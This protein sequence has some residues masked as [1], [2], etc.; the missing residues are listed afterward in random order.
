MSRLND[1][2][3]SV[4]PVDRSLEAVV[5]RR[6]D[7]LTKPPGSLGR[8]EDLA[9][10][11]CLVTGTASPTVGRKRI[12]TFAG[13]HGVAAEGVS[14]YPAEVTPQMVRNMLA[15][16]AAVNVLARHVGAE[17]Q[18][19]DIG[20]NDPL[21]D[22][23]GLIAAKVRPG[24]R[25][26]AEGPAMTVEEATQAIEVG[27]G[28]AEAA[29]GEGV[30][31]LGTGEMGIANTTPSAALAAA[32]LP[33]EPEE[34]TGRGTGIDDARLAHKVS[35]VKRALHANAEGL[36]DPL[37]ALAA[38]GGFEIAGICGL[39][40]GGAARRMGVVIDGFISSAAAL[41]A[42][43]MNER[44]SDYL[45]FSHCSAEAGHAPMLERMGAHPILD[46]GMRLGEGTGAALAMSVIEASVKA[47]NEMASFESAGVSGKA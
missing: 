45:F 25:N 38:L 22:A 42:R 2:M 13:D 23:P 33:C 16:G 40:L 7:N 1:T 4:A 30:T 39:I 8:L 12:V 28:V 37:Q 34:I 14:A 41:V 19:V 3:A 6:L 44:V 10:Q 17:V 15:G 29:H 26:I 18:V 5:R 32:L 36:R 20:V 21:E 43:G 47:Y 46:L 24:T 27:I 35:V 11:Y 9:A 31:L